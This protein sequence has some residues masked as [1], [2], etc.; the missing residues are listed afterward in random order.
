MTHTAQVQLTEKTINPDGT[1]QITFDDG[2]GLVY[3][4]EQSIILDCEARDISFPDYLKSFLVCMLADT[5][6]SVIGKTLLLD[7][8]AADGNIVKVI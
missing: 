2:T 7:I 3:G 4:D 6:I 5:G 8:D 1:I